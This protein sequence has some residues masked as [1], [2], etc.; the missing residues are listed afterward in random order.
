M[1]EAARIAPHIKRATWIMAHEQTAA[2]G[3]AGRA[4]ANPL[5]N[6]SATFVYRPEATALQAAQRSFMAANAL[7]QTLAL[8]VDP[9]KLSLKWPN[10]VLLSGGKVAG[11]L[12]EASGGA[13]VDWLAIGI[14]VNLAEAPEV[15]DAAF[16]PVALSKFC[17]AP[18]PEDFLRDLASAFATQESKLSALGFARIRRDWLGQ[19]ARLGE[20]ITARTSRDSFE[21]TFRDVDDEGNLVL[22]TPKGTVTIAAADVYF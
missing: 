5:G 11:I 19:A 17:T 1:A 16:P 4:W 3:R 10:D 8:H 18:D 7:Y 21:G 2:R 6:F 20:V 13:K 22:E 14:G 9:S 12:L 15:T